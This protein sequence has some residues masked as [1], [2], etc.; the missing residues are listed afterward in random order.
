MYTIVNY[1]NQ[2]AGG[3]GGEK[4]ASLP[5][6]W[7]DGAVGPGKLLQAALAPEARVAG[8]IVCGDDYVAAHSAGALAAILSYVREAGADAL[9]AGPAFGAGRYGVACSTVC[10]ACREQLKIPAITAMHRENPGVEVARPT[11]IVPT[12]D[13]ALDMPEAVRTLARLALKLCRGEALGP[14]AQEGYLPTG[15][16]KNIRVPLNGAQRATAM[17]LKKIAGV[18]FQ[19]EIEVPRVDDVPPASPL[20]DLAHATVA[21][22][23]SGGIVPKG[24]PDRLESRRATKWLKYSIAGLTD[25]SPDEFECIHGGFDGTATNKDPDRVTPIDALRV[26]ERNGEIG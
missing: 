17:L 11:L 15:V 14:A 9:V 13:T 26:L 8:T 22:V 24:N 1:L 3:V 7:V 19:T 25:L 5:P 12:A 20:D 10:E 16:K 18:P 2:F 4:S 21:L 23:S 6:K